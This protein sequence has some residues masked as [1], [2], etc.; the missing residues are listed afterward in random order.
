MIFVE[1]LPSKKIN[2]TN[3]SMALFKCPVCDKTFIKTLSNGDRNRTCGSK[4]CK[5][6]I[7]RIEGTGN[8]VVVDQLNFKGEFIRSFP[9]MAHASEMMDVTKTA[10]CKA[11]SNGTKCKG[12]LW[13]KKKQ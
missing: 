2:N 8:S 10:I 4:E 7:R 6:F 12:F 3:R 5:D 11:V 1:H 13:R 9:S